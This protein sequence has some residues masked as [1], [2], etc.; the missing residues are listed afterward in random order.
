MPLDAT[1]LAAAGM[2]NL[3]CADGEFSISFRPSGVVGGYAQLVA[4]AH[5]F[6]VGEVEVVVTGLADVIRPEEPAG[7]PEDLRV[8]PMPYRHQPATPCSNQ[9][10]ET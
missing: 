8:L 5:G 10:A 6:R 3:I 4:D 7:R 2:W 9:R 1:S